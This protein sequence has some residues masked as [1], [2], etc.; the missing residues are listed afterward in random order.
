MTTG[1]AAIY[2]EPYKFDLQE[3]AVPEV[4]PGGLL[5]KI[6]AAGICGSDLHFYR[7]HLKPGNWTG[8]PLNRPTI[9]GHESTGIVAKLGAEVNTDSL[10][11]DLKEGDRVAYTY[12]FPCLKCYNCLRGQLNT[13]PNRTR[14]RKPVEESPICSGG[15]AEYFYLPRGHFVFKVP[16]ELSDA[17]VAPVN[18]A[19]SQVIFGL[20]K[21]NIR[22]GDTVVIQGA[23][24]LGINAASAAKEMGASKVI[25]LDG[26]RNRLDL[27]LECGADEV[28]DITEYNTP[29]SR[30]ARVK[31]LSEGR[32]GDIVMELVGLPDAFTE[33]LEL[34]RLGGTLVEIGNMWKG[35][36]TSIDVATTVWG[37]T[38]V[39]GIA[40]YDP[41]TLPVAMD[42]LVKTQNK[43]SL[44]KLMSHSFP[45][46]EINQ[47][48]A[49]A[50]WSGK[51]DGTKIT[52]AYLRP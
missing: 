34:T 44:P 46:S 48:F 3:L 51:Q 31:E 29:E 38:T 45:L 42:F 9:I 17:E 25:I 28:I 4:E 33:G 40:H 14:I 21:A 24:G 47:A 20:N 11:R 32:G 5:V 15:F 43:Y 22:L 52:R 2:V 10:G 1:L 27:A 12:F 13:C 16:N 37:N 23:G 49:E 30:I 18:C 36:K 41:Y 50:E 7:G 35:G 6:T 19:V 26:S 8:D 39:I